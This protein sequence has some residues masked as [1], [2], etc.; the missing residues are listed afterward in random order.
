MRLKKH[1]CNKSDFGFGGRGGGGEDFLLGYE[2]RLYVGKD[3]SC[4][5][6]AVGGE[7]NND[8]LSVGKTVEQYMQIKNVKHHTSHVMRHTSHVTRHTLIHFL[9]GP[10]LVPVA[11]AR[12]TAHQALVG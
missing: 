12:T 10:K 9:R 3:C 11:A 2:L 6:A 5:Q 4:A 7:R 8:D 1:K